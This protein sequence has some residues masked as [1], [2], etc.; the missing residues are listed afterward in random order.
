VATAASAAAE[1]L[2]SPAITVASAEWKRL[3]SETSSVL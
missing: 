3:Q 1:L 2:I